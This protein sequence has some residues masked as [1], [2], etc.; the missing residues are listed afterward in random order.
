MTNVQIKSPDKKWTAEISAV[1]GGNVT[2]LE[3]CEKNVLI[4]LENEEQLTVNPYLQGSPIL[5]P[6]NRTYKGEFEFEGVLYH[7]PLNEPHN[8]AHL[9]GLV[10]LQRFDI[11]SATDTRVTLRYFGTEEVYPFPFSMTVEYSLEENVFS[12]VYVIKNIG[13]KNM[14]F[15]FSLHTTF[16]EP[17]SF[18]VPISMCQEKDGHH[19]PTGRYVELDEEELEY[20]NASVS[21]GRVISG[22]Y[23]ASGHTARVGEYLYSVS[24]NFDHFILFNGRGEMGL[25]C[26]EPQCGAVNGLRNGD[27][28]VLSPNEEMTFTCKISRI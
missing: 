21:R 22:Y 3:Y 1:H 7:L 26:V 14:P 10:H 15:T 4:P 5:F 19:I 18:S 23:K 13:T 17:E 25:L 28:K 20:A 11:L 24:D 2:R 16:S 27:C 9:H 6:A 12:Q 8:N